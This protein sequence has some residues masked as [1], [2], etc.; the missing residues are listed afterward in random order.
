MCIKHTIHPLPLLLN[1]CA[2]KP[3][4][5]RISHTFYLY[6]LAYFLFSDEFELVHVLVYIVV[7]DA[8]FLVN[9][10]YEA[11][12]L[13]YADPFQ[14]VYVL[15]EKEVGVDQFFKGCFPAYLKVQEKEEVWGY[16]V[17]FVI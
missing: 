6:M 2:T 15:E 4:T 12:D 7:L 5:H 16:F 17:A 3:T 9:A 1:I 14:D 10:F 13:G 11:V 8:E